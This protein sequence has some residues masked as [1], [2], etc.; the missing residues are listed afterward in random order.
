MADIP[1]KSLTFPDLTD[2]YTI[3]ER[4]L[5]S[6]TGTDSIKQ[7][8]TNNENE[9]T[10]SGNQAIALGRKS[11][12]S[13]QASIAIGNK[14]STVNWGTTASANGAIAIGA[15][16]KAAGAL[17]VAIGQVAQAEDSM[18]FAFGNYS[19]AKAMYSVAIGNRAISSGR[20]CTVLGQANVEDT[21][22]VDTTHGAGARKYILIVGNGTADNARSNAL[23]VDWDGN[24]VVS[25]S[26]SA[27]YGVAN[28][29][30]FLVVG[31]D[32]IVAPV[33]MATWQGGSY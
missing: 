21:N 5:E 22:A 27:N 29:G 8:A 9:N 16:A 17:S 14:M 15:S 12:A 20:A 18:G 13:G 2:T 28:A 3:P 26:M 11:V 33:A 23:T 19:D 31:S 7:V 25:G 32:G 24:L 6:G 30:K 4:L 1:L 10:A